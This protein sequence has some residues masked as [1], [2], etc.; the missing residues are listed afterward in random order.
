MA[1]DRAA[2]V[3][4]ARENPHPPAAEVPH[5]TRGS[6]VECADRKLQ[7]QLLMGEK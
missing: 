7:C 1:A 3:R 5:A 6:V 4:V 2:G